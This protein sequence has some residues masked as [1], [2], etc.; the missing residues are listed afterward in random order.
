MAS[1]LIAA[2]TAVPGLQE[3][4]GD[5]YVTVMQI[6]VCQQGISTCQELHVPGMKLTAHPL[7]PLTHCLL[8]LPCLGPGTVLRASGLEW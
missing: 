6:W 7:A 2:P 1:F 5:E 4:L 3:D 8:K